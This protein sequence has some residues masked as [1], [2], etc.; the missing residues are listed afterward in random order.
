VVTAWLAG[1]AVPRIIGY[2]A[3]SG[4]GLAAYMIYTKVAFGSFTE[5][6]STEKSWHR[7]ENLPFVG[8]FGNLRAIRHALTGTSP[9]PGA[10]IPSYAN[11]RA[12]WVL[13]DLSLA[14]ATLVIAYMLGAAWVARRP[15]LAANHLPPQPDQAQS[16]SHF[17]L[18][19]LLSAGLIVLLAACTTIHPYGRTPFYSTEGE[20]RFVVAAMPLFGGLGVLLRRRA[21]LTSIALSAS[22][23]LAVVFQLMF[24][25]GYWVT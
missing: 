19:W 20:E 17:P 4:V 15:R 1:R 18:A 5:P 25:L 21:A 14:V 6:F 22:V 24:N 23:V 9:G 3:L 8:L 16:A 2:A 11:V 12:M 13:D 7:S 10:G